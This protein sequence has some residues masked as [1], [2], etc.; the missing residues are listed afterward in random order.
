M[1]EKDLKG[2]CPELKRL[3]RHELA[4]GNRVSAVETGWSKV[5][6]AVRLVGPLDMENIREA[7]ARNPDLE[8]WESLDIKH[9]RE[10]GVLCKSVRQS[11][12][13]ALPPVP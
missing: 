2:L 9:P 3:L 8:I 11:L 4:A 13:G 1:N 10:H 6:M 12:S 5:S 7:A